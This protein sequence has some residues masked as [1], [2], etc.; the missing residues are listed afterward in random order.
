LIEEEKLLGEGA[1]KKVYDAGSEVIQVI[2]N[3]DKISSFEREKAGLK[4]LEEAGLDHVG[5]SDYKTIE[6]NGKKVAV[7]IAEKIDTTTI[8]ENLM[9]KGEWTESHTKAVASA[10]KQANENG[11][12]LLDPNPGNVYFKKIN[13]KLKASFLEGDGIIK[14][15]NLKQNIIEIGGKKYDLSTTKGIQDLQKTILTGGD[16]INILDKNIVRKALLSEVNQKLYYAQTGE[17]LSVEQLPP[18]A[19]NP[20]GAAAYNGEVLKEI[21][22]PEGNVP[23]NT[24]NTLNNFTNSFESAYNEATSPTNKAT[25]VLEANQKLI[26]EVEQKQQALNEK[27]SAASASHQA[28]PQHSQ[29]V[30]SIQNFL[31]EPE[32]TNYGVNLDLPE[33]L[34]DFDKAEQGFDLFSNNGDIPGEIQ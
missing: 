10:I 1:Y 6:L 19:R 14:L 5:V 7:R 28:Q 12:L 31:E 22:Y 23:E 2:D 11:L 25:N 29:E 18:E 8:G 13:G 21:Y 4:L 33:D 30:P 3:P 34:F 15:K 32:G 17:L 9:K 27:P 20:V 24:L 16:L 26:S